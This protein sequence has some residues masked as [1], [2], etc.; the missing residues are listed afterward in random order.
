M[1]NVMKY[2]K[3]LKKDPENYEAR[4]DYFMVK[5]NNS[6]DRFFYPYYLYFDGRKVPAEKSECEKILWEYDTKIKG[7]QAFLF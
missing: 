6:G 4:A 1:K 5:P 3:I 7:A 2:A